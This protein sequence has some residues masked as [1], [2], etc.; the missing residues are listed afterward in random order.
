M[1]KESTV[2][3]NDEDI[4]EKEPSKKAT[5]KDDDSSD[6]EDPVADDA[7]ATESKIR[8]KHADECDYDA[9]MI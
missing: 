5:S 8:G 9:G 7:D 4:D 1:G 3:G 6:D 2:A